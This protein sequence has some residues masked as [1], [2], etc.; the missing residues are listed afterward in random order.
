MLTS[1][2]GLDDDARRMVDYAFKAINP[3]RVERRR[4]MSGHD[5]SVY[6]ESIA[7]DYDMIYGDAFDT[8]GAVA[9]LRRLA[10]DGPVLEFGVGTG[11]LAL[12]LAYAGL[13]VHGIDGSEEMLTRLAEKAARVRIDTRCGDFSTT[14]VGEAARFALVV[15]AVNTIYALPDQAAQL[16]CCRNAAW[17]LRPGGRFVVEAWVPNLATLDAPLQPR[18]LSEGYVGLV[19]GDHDPVA[20][21][22]A[23]LQ[24]VLGHDTVR[25]FPVVHRYAWPSELDLMAQLSNLTL[26]HR[27]ED[28]NATPFSSASST[29][30]SVYRSTEVSGT[31]YTSAN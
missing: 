15:L 21:T 31:T 24:I 12:P 26:E 20:Q 8:D 3:G 4:I 6:G 27:W 11:R 29:H 13:E 2:V 9:T 18:R 23:T 19:V 16:Q 1:W 5:P 10:G 22:L 28:W 17:H 7:D 14:R 25:V 30:V